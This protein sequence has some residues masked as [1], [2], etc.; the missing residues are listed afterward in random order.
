MK[1]KAKEWILSLLGLT[2][3]AMLAAVAL[4]NFLIPFKILDGGL[5][6]IGMIINFL[7][8]IPLSIL[9]VLLNIPFF[10]IGLIQ[11][12]KAFIVKYA[13]G[14]TVFSLFLEYFKDVANA[15]QD[16][17]LAT[18]FGGVILG[19]GVGMVI[20]SGGCI[21]GTEMVAILI[22]KKFSFSVGQIILCFNI[23]IYCTAGFLFGWDRAMYSLI[24][25]F[26]T[27]KLIDM[28]EIG[29]SKAKAVM[30]ITN[31]G[32]LIADDI[33]RRLGRTV[34]TLQGEGLI[35][36]SKS[37]L[38]CVVTQLELIE[39]RNIVREDDRSAFM[40]VSDVA[41]IVGSHIKKNDS[42]AAAAGNGAS[43]TA[44]AD[45]KNQELTAVLEAIVS[46]MDE[47]MK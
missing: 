44:P 6:G 21:D 25:Y 39:L 7:T 1:E 26:I 43:D 3:G 28:V 5:N 17:L 12:G 19:I 15:T 30:I 2:L 42:I 16:S 36:G 23:V 10:I 33:Y 11:L 35:S 46:D 45:Q 18:V 22:N 38:Y 41:E 47:N 37:V 13:Y 40:T 29:F 31:D 20:R 24:A 4:E 14:I 32:R 8:D 9:V 34:T 27:S